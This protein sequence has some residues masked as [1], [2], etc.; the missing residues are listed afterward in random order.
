M[1][2]VIVPLSEVMEQSS[3]NGQLI[4][5]LKTIRNLIDSINLINNKKES[6]TVLFDFDLI[7][8]N[9]AYYIQNYMTKSFYYR[10]PQS[11]LDQVEAEGD[12]VISNLSSLLLGNI[13]VEKG[14]TTSFEPGSKTRVQLFIER[15][16]SNTVT[17]TEL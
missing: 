4:E 10:L 12:Y 3:K 1:N 7:D 5:K 14:L 9:K 17:I 13:Q 2:I 11:K 15:I 6:P 16:N 8:E